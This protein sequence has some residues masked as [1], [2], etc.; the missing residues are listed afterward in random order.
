[1]GKLEGMT[2]LVTGAG[3]KRGLGRAI[4]LRAA[5]E[6]ADVVVSALPRPPESLPAH[7]R[8]QG[9]LGSASVAEEIR[10]LGVRALAFDCDVTRR[11]QVETLFAAAEAQFGVVDGVVNNAGVASLAG[12][13]SIAEMDDD[14]WYHTVDVNLN[15]PYLISKL[16]VRALLAKG[17]GGAI[18][19]ISSMAGRVGLPNYGAYC[20]TKFGLIGLTQQLAVEVA[21]AGIRVNCVCPGST[22]TDMMDSTFHRAAERVGAAFDTVKSN[23]RTVIPMGRQGIPDEQAA[24]VVF[25]LGPDASFITGQTLNVDGGMRMD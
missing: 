10:A 3:R 7:E 9:W 16:A 24:A 2:V 11:D 4:A 25:L 21:N 15:G 13:A 17:K 19:N 20:A 14:N 22:D 6:G 23:V 18:V 8:E 1:M 5:A 12:A